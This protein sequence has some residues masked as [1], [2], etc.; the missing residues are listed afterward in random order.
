MSVQLCACCVLWLPTGAALA[1]SDATA[2]AAAFFSR[3]QLARLLRSVRLCTLLPLW[4]TVRL[5]R[6]RIGRLHG[7]L[8]ERHLQLRIG[9]R[10]Y[11]S[12]TRVAVCGLV[13][14]DC[15]RFNKPVGTV[16]EWRPCAR[17]YC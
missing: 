7:L 1:L 5:F 12:G 8:R 6:P 9:R 10:Q 14:G 4:T 3:Q 13:R 16:V 11:P 2:A 15:A 17:R